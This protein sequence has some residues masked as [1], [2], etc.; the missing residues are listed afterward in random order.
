[1]INISTVRY[2]TAVLIV[3][4]LSTF[5][6]LH[7]QQKLD[8]MSADVQVAIEKGIDP[9]A[10]RCAYAEYKDSIC[11]VY[12]ANHKYGVEVIREPAPKK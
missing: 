7:Q 4:I 1:M 11:L 10:V 6:F 5:L 8:L 3:F 2:T 12:A 9:L